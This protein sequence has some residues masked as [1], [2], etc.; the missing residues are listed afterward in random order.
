VADAI[1]DSNNQFLRFSSKLFQPIECE[2]TEDRFLFS[3]S[4][5]VQKIQKGFSGIFSDRFR[6]FVN[7]LVR[8]NL[9]VSG[10]EIS[11]KNLGKMLKN[12]FCKM[13]IFY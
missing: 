10:M 6:L 2:Q 7:Y 12:I 3:L 4:K 11:V 8:V 13:S 9:I 5:F 1:L